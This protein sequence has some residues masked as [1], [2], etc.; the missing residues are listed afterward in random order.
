MPS[1]DHLASIAKGTTEGALNWS[2]EQIKELVYKLK[3]REIGFL[4]NVER[5][6][7]VNGQRHSPEGDLSLKYV[8]NKEHRTL[9]SLGLAMRKIEKTNPSELDIY[10]AKISSKF[11]KDGL[12]VA[13]FFQHGLFSRYIGVMVSLLNSVADMEKGVEEILSNIEKYVVF[14]TS[15]D[16]VD[17]KSGDIIVRL[18]ANQ[19]TSL[20]IAGLGTAKNKANDIAINVS[21]RMQETYDV[22][23]NEDANRITYFF[24]IKDT[25]S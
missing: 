16:N 21:N 10:K 17:N 9:A 24:K 13:E 15:G 11:G 18:Q 5:I 1:E 19:P 22:E 8:K 14:I 4:E 12:H 20:I 25:D 7:L 23:R 3:N 2:K 6:Q